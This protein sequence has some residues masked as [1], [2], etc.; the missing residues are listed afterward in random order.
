MATDVLGCFL[1]V[2]YFIF[3]RFVKYNLLIPPTSMGCVLLARR[4]AYPFCPF[5]RVW[6]IIKNYLKKPYCEKE[7][8]LG[9][10]TQQNVRGT[11]K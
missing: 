9:K 11:R 1:R 8:W 7:I 2:F 6:R 5:P 3:F 10:N 4:L